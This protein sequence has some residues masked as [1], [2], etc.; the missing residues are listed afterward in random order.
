[1]KG[2]AAEK[3]RDRE[4]MNVI[5][6]GLCCIADTEAEAQAEYD[7]IVEK[8]DWESANNMIDLMASRARRSTTRRMNWP[9]GSSR[10][11]GACRLSA[12]RRRWQ[13]T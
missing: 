10:A 12:P 7:E 5:S 1:M 6:F 3:G 9:N 8:A 2:R 4:E 13:M 11:M